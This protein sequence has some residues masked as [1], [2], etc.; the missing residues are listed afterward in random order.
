[1]E[2]TYRK[3]AESLYY[4]LCSNSYFQILEESVDVGN[5]K[6]AVIRYMDFSMVE[7]KKYGELYLPENEYY[8]ASTWGK[9]L[10]KELEIQKNDERKQFI[11]GQMGK[12]S[13]EIYKSISG[14]MDDKSQQLLD[15]K[16]WYLSIVGVHPQFQGQGLGVNLVK[17]ILQKTDSLGIAT[18]LETFTSRNISFYKRLNYQ[19]AGCF[20]EP[21]TNLEYQLMIRKVPV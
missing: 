6:E 15:K 1:M 7:A 11:L 2:F 4:S 8:G 16:S 12:K 10:G 13:W 20:R 17:S 3:H 9:P 14:F 21:I 5:Q 18:Y 19:I